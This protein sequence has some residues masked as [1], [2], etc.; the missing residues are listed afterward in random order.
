MKRSVRKRLKKQYKAGDLVTW[1]SG[2]SSHRVVEVQE[3]GVVVDVTGVEGAGQWAERQKDGGHH[4]Y[5]SF[6]RNNRSRS[7]R[8]PIRHACTSEPP[9]ENVMKKRRG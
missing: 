5:V 3:H 9:L 4:L 7:G 1:G 6:D 8:G 2:A